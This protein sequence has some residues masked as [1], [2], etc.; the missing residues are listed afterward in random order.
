MGK[1][2]FQ[3]KWM[4]D[5]PWLRPVKNDVYQA[6]CMQCLKKFRVDGSGLS[7]VKSHAKCHKTSSTVL[8]GQRTFMLDN[9]CSSVTLSSKVNSGFVLCPEELVLNAE[10]MQA[11][12]FVEFNYSFASASTDS[13]R[14]ELM[15]PD[16]AIAKSYSQGRSKVMYSIVHGI[17]PYLNKWKLVNELENDVMYS[18]K[19]DETTTSQVKKQYDGYVQFWWERSPKCLLRLSICRALY[20]RWLTRTFSPLHQGSEA[21][22][23]SALRSEYGWAKR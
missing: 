21:W 6:F 9:A 1:T 3:Q 11:L 5:F 8:Q 7:Q 17:A 14:F 13:K 16:S 20:C 10:I 23:S 19:F 18:F 2:K 15:F 4:K 22:S 12:H